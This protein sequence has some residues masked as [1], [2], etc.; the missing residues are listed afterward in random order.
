MPHAQILIPRAQQQS[1]IHVSLVIPI[2]QQ[3]IVAILPAMI[4]M[5]PIHTPASPVLMENTY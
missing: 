2:L 3:I 1:A 5:G 4:A